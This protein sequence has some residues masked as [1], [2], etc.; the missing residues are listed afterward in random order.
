MKLSQKIASKSHRVLLF[1]PPK[2]GKT[3]LAGE[4]SKEYNLL[5]FDLENGVD[6]LLKLPEEQKERIKDADAYFDKSDSQDSLLRIV[7][8]LA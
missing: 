4:L 1:G 5:W 6:T 2:S 7:S 3:Q 8:A